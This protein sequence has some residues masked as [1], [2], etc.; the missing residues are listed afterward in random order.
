MKDTINIGGKI[1]DLQKPIIMGI[2]NITPDSF[3]KDSR[4]NPF[5]E[6]FLKKAN[7]MLEN[8][9]SIIDIGGYSSRPGAVDISENEEI[10]RVIP[11]IEILVKN[12]RD[13]TIS[14]DTFRAKVA[15]SALSSGAKLVNDISAGELDPEMV[16]LIIK[17]N[18]PY[19]LMHMRGNPET[20]QNLTGYENIYSE[21]LEQLDTKANFLRKNGVRDIIIDPGFGFSKTIEQNYELMKN[22]SIFKNEN[23]PI[24]VGISRKSMIY[25]LLKIDS[26]E[27]L[28][29]TAQLH[30]QALLAGANILR[31]HDVKSAKNS[32]E[33]YKILKN[34]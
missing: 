29:A 32:V 11:A 21:I 26:S 12:F 31:V 20:M 30:L 8:G 34:S 19:I 27:T 2:M 6:D 23:Y 24:L 15:Y 14:I 3:H 17:N 5:D 13:V 33:L 18:Y 9:A 16:P 28:E 10:D 4:F 25:K 7:E 22:L 1:L